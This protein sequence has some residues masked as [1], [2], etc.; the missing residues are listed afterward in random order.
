MTCIELVCFYHGIQ[1]RKIHVNSKLSGEYNL[2][3][4]EAEDGT[5]S[6]LCYDMDPPLTSLL[7]SWDEVTPVP[8]EFWAFWKGDHCKP[9]MLHVCDILRCGQAGSTGKLLIRDLE[10]KRKQRHWWLLVSSWRRSVPAPDSELICPIV[11]EEDMDIL[12]DTL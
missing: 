1:R 5:F 6:H 10:T 2:W 12:R 11:P 9:S 4:G 7:M 3:K 8:L